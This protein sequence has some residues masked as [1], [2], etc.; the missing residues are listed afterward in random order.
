MEGGDERTSVSLEVIDGQQRLTTLAIMIAIII[1]SLR[2]EKRKFE[3]KEDFINDL[4][5]KLISYTI[6]KRFDKDYKV[7]TVLKVERSDQ[8]Q[9]AYK[10]II[11][12]LVNEKII[13]KNYNDLTG[14]DKKIL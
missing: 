12:N 6:T 14:D 4:V 11:L 3:G 13:Y 10:R 2:F 5:E 7:S 8:L 9:E 1:Q